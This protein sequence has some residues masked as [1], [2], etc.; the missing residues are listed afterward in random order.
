MNARLQREV[1][2]DRQSRNHQRTY[3]KIKGKY[4][5]RV[6]YTIDDGQPL[7][8]MRQVETKSAIK[9][10]H[11]EIE[12]E[13][14]QHGPPQLV[15]GKVTFRQL[16]KYAKDNIYVAAVYDDQETTKITG[17]RSVVPAHACLN[18]LVAFFGDIDIKKINE[19]KLAQYQMARLTGTINDI[20][21]RRA[22]SNS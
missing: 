22:V 14:L 13:L 4:Y 21:N 20:L 1:P 18:N 17:V 5:A 2:N 12:V 8:I 9:S 19:K 7:D 16:A 10:K 11:A 3:R 6:R 15:A